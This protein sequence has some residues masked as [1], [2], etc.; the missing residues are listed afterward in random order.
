[1]SIR[2]DSGGVGDVYLV[3]WAIKHINQYHTTKT[4]REDK[5]LSLNA[6]RTQC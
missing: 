3:N 4:I 6:Q 1:M 2:I 5:N